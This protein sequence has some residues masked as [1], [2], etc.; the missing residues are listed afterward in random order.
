MQARCSDRGGAA[1]GRRAGAGRKL[2]ASGLFSRRSC[3]SARFAPVPR[4]RGHN[5]SRHSPSNLH[6]WKRPSSSGCAAPA[7]GRRGV[8]GDRRDLLPAPLAGGVPGPGR[9]R[10][11]RGRGPEAFL[12]AWRALDRFDEKAELSTWLYRIAINAA[13]DLQAG[14]EAAA[15]TGGS[16]P[17]G[18]P[19][20][21]STVRV[22]GARPARAGGL[23]RARGPGA[24]GDRRAAGGGAHGDPAP[25]LRG[26]LD[27][28]DRARPGRRR[29]RR[30]AGGLPRGAQ[31][32]RRARPADGDVPW[33]IGLTTS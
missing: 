1:R 26:M 31:A 2:D 8:P 4:R 24:R 25:A 11:G 30:Q 18:L 5:L 9:R 13:I 29:E 20:A 22:A 32:A 33:R 17:R 27:R 10:G 3:V 16:A 15:G 21:R 7:R 23:A 19:T 6:A 12:R 14:A 28:R